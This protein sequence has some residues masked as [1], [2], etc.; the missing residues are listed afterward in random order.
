MCECVAWVG[1]TV[2]WCGVS[3]VGV[4]L[5]VFGA[6]GTALP[7]TAFPRTAL[8]RTALPLD[9][10]K[11]RS[12]FHSPAASGPPGLHTTTRELQS[13]HLSAPALQT[14]PKFHEK[15]K[16]ERETKR[17]KM[18]AGEGKKREILGPPPFGPPLFGPQPLWAPTLRAP[19]LSGLG[20]HPTGPHS[21]NPHPSNLHFLGPWDPTLSTHSRQQLNTHNKNLNN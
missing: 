15:T 13:A 4:G 3:R 1:F 7:R 11:F 12:F 8:P 21:S 2:S 5:V 18:R 14:Q 20:P 9:R 16:Q 17:A 10:P 6:P 19:T